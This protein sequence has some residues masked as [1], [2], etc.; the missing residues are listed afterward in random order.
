MLEISKLENN[1]ES[2]KEMINFKD[3][4]LSILDDLKGEIELKNLKV[5]TNLI[6]LN[7]L[8]NKEES[9]SLIF[10]LISNAINYN[11]MNG[12]IS[13]NIK[14]NIISIKDTGIGIKKDD[15]NHI[16]ER[17]YMVD[18]ARSKEKGSTG[19]G[20][21]ICKHIALNNHIEIKVNS[22]VDEGSEFLLI[23]PL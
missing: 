17:F 22:K 12:L 3:I 9:R 2:I 14:D 15:I 10:N 5:E 18:K 20:L 19:L 6:D 1:I 4:I 16:F 13:I 11:K 21:S 8:M 23:F 7:Y